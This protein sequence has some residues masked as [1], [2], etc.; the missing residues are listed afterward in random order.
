MSSAIAPV[1]EAVKALAPNLATEFPRSPRVT[2]G[3]FVLAGRMLDKCRAV[4]AGTNGEYHFN[5]PLD[6]M[7]LEFSGLNADDFKAFVATG[8]TDEAVGAWIKE[9]TTVKN[10]EDV[11]AWNNKMRD[12][13]LS[14]LPVSLQVYMEDYIPQFVP[15]GKIVYRFFDV[16]DYE[17]GR[18]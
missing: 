7:V 18:L 17:E 13:S 14:G 12:T 2:I 15:A 9:Q 16:Y 1:S 10:R 6:K 11:V 3:G 4:L 5:C 8:A